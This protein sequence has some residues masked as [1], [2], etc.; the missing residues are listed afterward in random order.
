[1]SLRKLLTSFRFQRGKVGESTSLRDWLLGTGVAAAC[2]TPIG[3]ASSLSGACATCCTSASM[4]LCTNGAGQTCNYNDTHGLPMHDSCVPQIGSGGW[5]QLGVKM[6]CPTGC[7][8]PDG[9]SGGNDCS[10]N[11]TC[12]Y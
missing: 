3:A 11:S 1:M 2:L 12:Y 9:F 5:V 8:T 10:Q 6:Q 4:Q 7:H